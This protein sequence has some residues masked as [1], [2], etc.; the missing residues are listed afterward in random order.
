MQRDSNRSRPVTKRQIEFL[1]TNIG[2]GHPSYLDGI[3]AALIRSG[4]ISLVRNETDVFDVSRGLSFLTWNVARWLYSHGSS[5]GLVG[6]LYNSLR[7]KADYNRRN[8]MINLMGRSLRRRYY[9]DPIPLVVA[10]PTLVAILKDRSRLIYQHGELVAPRESLAQGAELVF[11]PTEGVKD[12]FVHSG[13]ARGAVEVSGLCIEPSLVRQAQDAFRARLTRLQSNVPLTVAFYSS[14]AEPVDHVRSLVTAAVSLIESGGR[15][16]VICL[17]QGR[18]NVRSQ[19]TLAGMGILPISFGSADGFPADLPRAMIATYGN[20]REQAGLT[21]QLFPHFDCFVAP[22][23]ERSNW[24]VGL[25][26]PLFVVGPEKG[27]FAPLNFEL[28]RAHQVAERLPEPA[29]D[30]GDTAAGMRTRGRLSAMAENG[31]GRYKI[32]G[33]ARIA[34]ALS[35]FCHR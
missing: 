3:T 18:L 26:L 28:L 4:K 30:F 31:W 33:F 12:S 27:S 2:R 25:G 20:R 19:A 29:S 8:L 22:A 7:S 35:D 34:G 10:H 11:V 5:P 32:D 21:A 15:A 24:A 6:R 13:Y 16:I 17:R 23:H 1:Y 9:D 14:G